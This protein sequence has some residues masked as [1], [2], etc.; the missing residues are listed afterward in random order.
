[1]PQKIKTSYCKVC[2]ITTFGHYIPGSP[3][4]NQCSYCGDTV[5]FQT[6]KNIHW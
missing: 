6:Q 1:M 2:D 4:G 3:D 5:V